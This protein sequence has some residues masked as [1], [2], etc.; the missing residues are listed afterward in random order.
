MK[1]ERLTTGAGIA[2]YPYVFK[3]DTKFSTE[4]VY[5]LT[6]RLDADE[7]GKLQDKLQAQLDEHLS[8]IEATTGKKPERVNNL[9]VKTVIDEQGNEVKDFKFKMKPSFKSKDGSKIEQRP[10]VFD[11]SLKP[12]TEDCALGTG[13]KVKVN[14]SPIP[15]S[16]QMGTGVTLRL[17]AVQVIDLVQWTGGNDTTSGFEVEEGFSSSESN[18]PASSANVPQ[19]A[20]QEE[21]TSA[22]NF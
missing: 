11:S 16:T 6:L 5:C 19:D 20:P 1:N 17:A 3:P 9:P 2:M 4:G 21:A 15:Y 13:S 18:A 10:A 12:L 22:S 8:S 7:G 14:F